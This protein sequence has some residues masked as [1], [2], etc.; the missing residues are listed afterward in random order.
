[1]APVKTE[2]AASEPQAPEPVLETAAAEAEPEDAAK[3]R[4]R[5][6]WSIGR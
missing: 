5:G 2:P 1:L 4:R 6:W 3:P